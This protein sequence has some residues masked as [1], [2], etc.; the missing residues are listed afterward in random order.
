MKLKGEIPDWLKSEWH[1]DFRPCIEICK[2]L[3]QKALSKHLTDV[4]EQEVGLLLAKYVEAASK[5]LYEKG[6]L[7]RWRNDVYPLEQAL[8][9]YWREHGYSD[10]VINQNGKKGIHGLDG[11]MLLPAEYE[12]VHFT[13]DD[14]VFV[15]GMHDFVV[16]QNG[17]WGVVDAKG[18]T[19]LP[20]E[21]DEIYR[22]PDSF[23][24][25]AIVK[26]GKQGVVDLMDDNMIPFPVQMDAVYYVPDWDLILF[27]K[28]GRWGWWWSEPK[29][30]NFF[31]NYSEPVYDEIF[32]QRSEFRCM[33]DDV[34]DFIYARKGDEL[35]AILYWTIK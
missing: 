13:Y 35:E 24:M 12:D 19:I 2:E 26:D 14:R 34:E 33:D 31:E 15:H 6:S 17:K 8:Q 32:V 23:R 29:D 5:I 21:Y 28:D 30:N 25:Y 11:N 3:E 27:T 20:F 18:E 10:F 4:Q 7:L 9:N 16:K 1:S 22:W